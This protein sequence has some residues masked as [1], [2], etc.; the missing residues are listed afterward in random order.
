M[1]LEHLLSSDTSSPLSK[2]IPKYHHHYPIHYHHQRTSSLSSVISVDQ[3]S[4]TSSQAQRICRPL[5]LSPSASPSSSSSSDQSPDPAP[6]AHID[7]HVIA[8]LKR[9]LGDAK[10]RIFSSRLCERRSINPAQIGKQ[11]PLGGANTNANVNANAN[12]KAKKREEGSLVVDQSQSP[13]AIEFLV[14]VCR[15]SLCVRACR[16]RS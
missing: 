11:L 8:F 3:V 16:R 12:C 4:P 7:P 2:V 14:K 6:P 13:C 10:W 1:N 15:L 9:H 5:T